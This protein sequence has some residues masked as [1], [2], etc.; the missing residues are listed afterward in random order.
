M[1]WVSLHHHTTFSFMDGFQKPEAHVTRTV[2]LGMNAQAV[3][4]HGNTSSHVQ[5]EKAALKHG[6]K[7][8]FGL[9]AYTEVKHRSRR[10]FHLT[11]LA[12]NEVGY[13]NLMRIVSRSWAEG[14]YQWP[15]VR[16]GMLKEHNEGLIVLSGC[17]D[18]L[19]ACSLLGGKSIP[20]SEASWERA[21]RQA[22]SFKSWLGDRFYLECQMFPE[23]ERTHSINAAYEGIG[24]ELGIP[25]VGTADV[26]YPYPEDGGKDGMQ[27]I[28]HA[29]GRGNNTVAAQ[30]ES[31]EYEIRLTHPTSDDQVLQRLL[32]TGLSK[33]AAGAALATTAEIAE[34]CNVTLP[35]AAP[36]SFGGT[37]RDRIWTS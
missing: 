8:I 4:E 12:M 19:L 25:L 33:Q 31:W 36:L 30:S 7:P 27:V 37:E 11:I 23:L 32:G 21:V 24:A 6:I 22:A 2:E 14:F 15:T 17:S 13:R 29:A 18:S 28:L 35:K 34:R 1:D 26:H 9:E 3:T 20:A 5:H 10:K 16:A